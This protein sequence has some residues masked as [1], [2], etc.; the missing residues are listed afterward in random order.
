[1]KTVSETSGTIVNTSTFELYGCQEEK[2]ERERALE[3]I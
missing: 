3:N 1:M 2:R